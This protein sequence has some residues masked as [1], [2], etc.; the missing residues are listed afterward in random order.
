MTPG[1]VYRLIQAGQLR[2]YTV[3][4]WCRPRWAPFAYRRVRLMVSTEA[5]EAFMREREAETAAEYARRRASKSGDIRRRHD[6]RA[7][8]VRS[9]P[10]AAGGPEAAGSE[11]QG[12]SRPVEPSAD[13]TS[14]PTPSP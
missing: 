10:A 1:Q 14:P 12:A 5:L 6:V 2:A 9:S 3:T 11:G 8:A 4:T 13:R 7:P